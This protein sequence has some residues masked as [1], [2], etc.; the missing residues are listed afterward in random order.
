MLQKEIVHCILPRDLCVGML[1]ASGEIDGKEGLC[2]PGGAGNVGYFGCRSCGI[3]QVWIF[4]LRGCTVRWLFEGSGAG[5]LCG[6][7]TGGGSSGGIA[8]AGM[9]TWE[10]GDLNGVQLCRAPRSWKEARLS[11][12]SVERTDS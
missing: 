3:S 8:R 12:S 10:N 9:G 5:G 11:A 4:A 7:S 6:A 2:A 1:L